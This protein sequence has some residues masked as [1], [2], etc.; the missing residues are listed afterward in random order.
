MKKEDIRFIT[1][2]YRYNECSKESL[3]ERY[4]E[5]ARLRDYLPNDVPLSQVNTEYLLNV[6]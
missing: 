2:I 6:Y 5:Q 1:K 4:P 3:Y